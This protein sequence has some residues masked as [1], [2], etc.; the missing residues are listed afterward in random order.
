MSDIVLPYKWKPRT[1]QMNVWRYMQG[2]QE[3]KRAACVWHRRAGKDLLGINLVSVKA[4]ERIGTYWHLLPT[5]KQG[6]AIVWN[7]STRDG[8]RFL[9]HFHPD[10][11]QGENNTEMRVTFSNNSN[12]QVVGTDDVN[13]LVGTNP[14]GCIFSEYS[15]HDPAAW[16]YIRPILKEN[17]GWAL[18]IYTARGHNHGWTLIDMAK[19]NKLWFSEILVAG[20]NGTKRSDNNPVFSD[21]DIEEERQSGMP[22]EMI[23]QEYYCSFD[24]SMVG[25]YY[26][27][28]MKRADDEGRILEFMPYDP[29]VP[30]DTFWDLGMD[31]V[32]SIWFAQFGPHEV[33]ILDYY[34]NSGEGLTHY[35]KVLRGQVSGGEHRA[36]Y[37]YGKHY[38]PHDIEVRELSGDGKSRRELAKDMGIKFNVVRKHEVA[39]GIEM[40]RSTIPKCFFNLKYAHRGI[41]GLRT[42]RKQ[43]D[44]KRKVFSSQPLHD[45]SSNPADAF[46]M[47]A[48]AK[49]ST[50]RKESQMQAVAIDNYKY[51]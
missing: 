19:R 10:L 50:G 43:W 7:G 47:L 45:W 41:E 44:E 49:R 29:R 25:S 18:F 20:D 33:R 51:L 12:Y 27:S 16:D 31:D 14:I 46:R 2:P 1:Y 22:E 42:Y 34:E 17:G 39:D 38:G 21:Q 48:M 23:Q 24:A 30:V 8:R 3:G 15:L 35:A 11:V 37:L 40:V 4:Q 28:Q 26:G 9:D 6:R 36:E 32:T 5:Y 13:S